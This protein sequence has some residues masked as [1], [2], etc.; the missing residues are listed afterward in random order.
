MTDSESSENEAEN[1]EV[2]M[3]KHELVSVQED[4]F[5]QMTLIG[6]QEETIQ[7]LSVK[8]Q[9]HTLLKSEHCLVLKHLESQLMQTQDSPV[10]PKALKLLTKIANKHKN[11]PVKKFFGKWYHCT[12]SFERKTLTAAM[13]KE[14]GSMFV[15]PESSVSSMESQPDLQSEFAQKCAEAHRAMVKNCG[16]RLLG[17]GLRGVVS[18]TRKEALEVLKL[19]ILGCIMQGAVDKDIH[20]SN[21]VST[22]S[23]LGPSSKFDLGEKTFYSGQNIFSRVTS[24]SLVQSFFKYVKA[25]RSVGDF[26]KTL[27]VWS[28]ARMCK[29]KSMCRAFRL[30]SAHKC[31]GVDISIQETPKKANV[32]ASQ[33]IPPPLP[34]NA[35]I[36][37]PLPSNAPIPPP[38]PGNVPIPPPLPSNAPI[39]PPLPGNVPIPPPLPSN[40]PI[41]P[42]LPSNVPIPPPLPGNAP[43][44][45]PLPGNAPIPPPLPGNGPIPPPLPGN[46][47]PLP[48]ATVSSKPQISYPVPPKDKTLKKLHWEPIQ[49]YKLKNTI[50]NQLQKPIPSIDFNTISALFEEQPTKS[51][52]SQP[53]KTQ[54]YITDSKKANNAGIILSSFPL[55]IEKTIELIDSLEDQSIELEQ[56]ARLSKLKP[57]Q[58]ELEKLQSYQGQVSQLVYAEQFMVELWGRM[59]YFQTRLE[60]L[61]F[62]KEFTTEFPEITQKIQTI[63]QSTQ[64]IRTSESFYTLLL[65][66]LKVGNYLNHGTNK[67]NTTGFSLNSLNQLEFFK[68]NNQE[69]TTLLQ[70]LLK[71]L[72]QTDKSILNFTTEFEICEEATKVDIT[73]IESKVNEL[74]LGFTKLNS[75]LEQTNSDQT[76]QIQQFN[77]EMNCFVKLAKPELEDLKNQVQKLKSEVNQ[78]KELFGE[79]K[80]VKSKEF[81]QKFTDFSA[82]CKRSHEKSSVQ[83]G[84]TQL[85]SKKKVVSQEKTQLNPKKTQQKLAKA[86]RLSVRHKQKGLVSL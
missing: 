23:T 55:S 43:I 84:K 63:S 16:A 60:C 14:F 47:P 29:F 24:G 41:P 86:V 82:S 75:A 12:Y 8:L 71:Q 78:C 2:E 38:L 74:Q 33:P 67:G 25:H 77:Y 80:E 73:D 81:F 31:V 42:P 59:P 83:E 37:P 3:L 27:Q 17:R 9:K 1:P 69:K 6:N 48:N 11:S 53:K 56:L 36:P 18:E 28:V 50:W 64:V 72:L 7:E 21:F 35:P 26:S 62:R 22:R 30:W 40:A 54:F 52:S 68:A 44:P 4:Y 76:P 34:G 20:K 61:V 79:N 66:V 49:K 46:G 70:L 10:K 65:A 19:H 39:P 51:V 58:E 5:R 32:L 57:T 85:N 15:A 13:A 45:P